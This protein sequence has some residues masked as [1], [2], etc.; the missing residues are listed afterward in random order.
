M[1]NDSVFD[2]L[3]YFEPFVGYSHILKRI[4]NKK[5]YNASDYNKLLIILLKYI[6]KNTIYPHITKEQYTSL[7][8][9]NTIN[10]RLNKAF[11]AFTYSYNGKFFGGYTDILH[12]RNYPEE[13][14]RYYKVLFNN[15]TFQKTKL[16]HTHFNT[17]NPKNSII[18]CDPP[19][20]NTTGY[21]MEPFDY[22]EFW[23]IMRKWSLNNF[24][25]ISEYTAPKDFNIITTAQKKMSI[26]GKGA[27]Q[28][29][30]ENL[31]AHESFFQTRTFKQ[32]RQNIT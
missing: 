31:Y 30:T 6:Q 11:A 18:Y 14:K 16:T 21:S 12:N 15:P 10:S 17:L 32:L 20:Q 9:D 8:N 24:V 19:Y 29:R 3:N 26:S 5:T 22:N 7:K 28:N 1:L 25:F 2:N 27:T 4:I 23:N 13:R